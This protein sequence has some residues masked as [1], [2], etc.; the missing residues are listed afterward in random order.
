MASGATAPLRARQMVSRR[1]V[2]RW[3]LSCYWRVDG[4]PVWEDIGLIAREDQDYGF[5]AAD[6]LKFMEALTRRLR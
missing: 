3:A 5:R 2:P 1:A 4:V 6:A